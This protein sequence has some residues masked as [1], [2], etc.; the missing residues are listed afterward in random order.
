[1]NW[2]EKLND[3]I[4]KGLKKEVP[5]WAVEAVESG[6]SAD[7]LVNDAIIPA[8]NQVSELW[9]KGEY[10]V[11]EVLRSASTMQATMDAL[12]PY[13]VSG[14]HGK[15]IKV[16]I[17]TV[18]GDLHDIGKNLVGIMLEGAGFQIENIGVDLSPERFIEAAGAGAKVIGLSSL[19]TTSM[20][21]MKRVID[22]FTERGLRKDVMIIVGGAPVTR[23]FAAKIGAD[24]YAD[25]AAE[26][27]DILNQHFGG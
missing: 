14:K 26:A 7:A 6:L 23:D 10:Y 22:V 13:L 17:G 25:D 19:L 15:G 1:M 3:G 16:A 11:P 20:G 8:M 2:L 5:G 21:E 18:K 4:V 9:K 27:V 12:K 24:Y